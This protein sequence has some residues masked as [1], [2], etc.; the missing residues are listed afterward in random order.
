MRRSIAGRISF[1]VGVLI[2]VI[3]LGLGFLAYLRGSSAVI[4]QVEQ[5]LLMQAEESAHYVESRITI[6][7]STLEAIAARPEIQS[8]DWTLQ[9]PVLQSELERLNL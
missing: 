9:Q 2:L 7:L 1:S 8:M 6:H 5:A 4:K 3:C